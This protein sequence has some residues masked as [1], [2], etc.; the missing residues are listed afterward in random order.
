MTDTITTLADWTA[1]ELAAIARTDIDNAAI[2]AAATDP[3][4]SKNPELVRATLSAAYATGAA[5]HAT[6]ALA[7]T[8]REAAASITAAIHHAKEVS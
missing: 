5:T 4:E 1:D 7:A 3:A 2:L 6:L 8:V